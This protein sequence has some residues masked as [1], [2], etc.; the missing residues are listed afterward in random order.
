[1]KERNEIEDNW[2]RKQCMIEN[3]GFDYYKKCWWGRDFKEIIKDVIRICGWCWF[4]T[5]KKH[6]SIRFFEQFLLSNP[7]KNWN[8]ISYIM[9]ILFRTVYIHE[10]ITR[11]PAFS[12]VRKNSL[13]KF[14]FNNIPPKNQWENQIK[15]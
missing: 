14:D 1:M 15:N 4:C 10:V 2:R 13:L 6:Y 5:K 3:C 8:S 7:N 11:L 9:V 12:F